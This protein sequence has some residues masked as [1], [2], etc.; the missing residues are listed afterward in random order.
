MEGNKLMAIVVLSIFGTGTV[1]LI[2]LG[3]IQ[4][5]SKTC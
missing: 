5:F 3:A 4:I 2:V 1:G